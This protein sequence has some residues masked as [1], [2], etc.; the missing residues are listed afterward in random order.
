MSSDRRRLGYRSARVPADLEGAA[1][2]SRMPGGS[3]LPELAP[4]RLSHELRTPL[5][6]ILGNAEL[7]LDGSAGPLSSQ[8]RACLGDIHEAGRTM[9]RQVQVLLDLCHARS[10]PEITG[11]TAIDLIEVLRAAYAAVLET[12]PSLQVVPAEAHYWVRGEPSGSARWRRP[13]STSPGPTA[14]AGCG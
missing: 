11:D 5:N 8:A 14:T 1:N 10:R 12:G 2:G 7:L 13:W 4:A 6:A 3:P 9:L